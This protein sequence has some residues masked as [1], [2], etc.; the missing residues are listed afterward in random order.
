MEL[1]RHGTDA[2]WQT[3]AVALGASLAP[4]QV[5]HRVI[6]R[7]HHR[8]EP[9]MATLVRACDPT[10]TALDIGAWYGPWTY[11]LSRRCQSVV[12]LE[13]NPDLA[14]GLRRCVRDNV[15]LI[16]AAA[17]DREGDATLH[18]PTLGKGS[19]GTATL[20]EGRGSAAQVSVH[21]VRVDSLGLTD[22]RFVKIDVEGHE[23]AVIT[24]AEDLLETQ[25][26]V[27]HVELDVRFAD[28]R[29]TITLLRDLG[30][31]GRAWWQ[32][33]WWTSAELDL[34]AW[35]THHADTA[36]PKGYLGA[37]LHGP[38]WLNDITWVHPESSWS[39][40]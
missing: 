22:V 19:E 24:G 10:G 21:T 2:G 18:L 11:W 32:G 26:P 27:V 35:Q 5:L 12:T 31:E 23:H 40:W 30:Y 36:D 6:A 34:A 16:E 17:S 8:A 9:A 13:P 4:P 38:S 25:H 29:P 20:E 39:P 7:V 14:Q 28:I 33:R 1:E 15:T 37:V 3:R